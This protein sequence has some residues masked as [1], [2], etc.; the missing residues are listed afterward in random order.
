MANFV[1]FVDDDIHKI[2]FITLLIHVLLQPN[3]YARVITVGTK[4]KI[5]IYSKREIDANEEIT[6][7]YKFAIE[8][9]SKKIRCLC[10]STHCRG[11]LN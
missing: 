7:D 8:E 2:F 10:K 1:L 5:V 6:Y 9:D 4:K 3:C 11:F